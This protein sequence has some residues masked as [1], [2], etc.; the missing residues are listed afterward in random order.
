MT[1]V[2]QALDRLAG[3]ERMP[4]DEAAELCGLDAREARR[5]IRAVG[6]DRTVRQPGVLTLI[7]ARMARR[8]VDAQGPSRS[9]CDAS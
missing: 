4:V 8:D 9:V 5:L 7:H 6:H 1:R 3:P 2:S